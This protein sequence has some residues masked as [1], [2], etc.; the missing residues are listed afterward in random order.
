M[1]VHTFLFF[2]ISTLPVVRADGWD[3]FSNNLATDLAPFLSLFGEQV[4]KQFLSESISMLDYFIF[5]MAPMGILTAVVSVIRVCG[6][7]SLRAFIGRAQ[8]GAGDAE[9]ELCSSTSR[10]VCEL[11]NKGGIARVFGRPKILEIIHDPDH[12]F[13]DEK[14]GIYTFQEY[15]QRKG[16]NAWYRKKPNKGQKDAESAPKE[17]PPQTAAAPNLSLN[18]GIK[19]LSDTAFW[20]IALAGLVLQ[21]GVLVFAGVVTYYLK[22][23]KDGGRPES[24]ACPLVM[25]GT[26]LVCSGMFYCAFLIGQSTDEEVWERN[27]HDI[28]SMYWVQ[29]GGQIVGDQ[30]FDAFSYTDSEDPK[31][32][33]QQYTTSRKNVSVDSK[34]EVWIAVGITISGFVLQFIGLRGIHS[35]VSVAQLGVV[36]VMSMARAALRMRRVEPD[37]NS[38]AKFPDEVLGHE[39]DWLAL[40]IGQRD[41]R[42]AL[43]CPSRGSSP[44]SL[45]FSSSSTLS[46][47]D[48]PSDPRVRYFWRFCG[49]SDLTDRI[50]YK[51]SPSHESPNAAAKLLAYRTRLAELTSSSPALPTSGAMDFKTEMVEVRRESQKLADLIEATVNTIFSIAKVKNEWKEA[52]SMYWGIKCTLCSKSTDLF[53]QPKDAVVSRKQYTV[54]LELTRSKD[55]EDF[56]SVGNPWKL[57]DTGRLELEGLLGLWIWSLKSDPAIEA[58]DP[59]TG[60]TKSGAAGVDA[61]QIVST[62]Q[63]FTE[64]ALRIWLGG[65][66]NSFTKHKLYCTPTDHGDAS[67]IWNTDMEEIWKPL[68]ATRPGQQQIRF[69][70]WNAAQFS[71]IQTPEVFGLWSVPTKSSL[72]SSCTKEV[73]ASLTTCVLGAVDDIGSIDIQEADTFRLESSLVT[74]IV[75]LFTEMD[76]GSRQEALT[77]VV[78]LLISR[79]KISSAENVLAAARRNANKHRRGKRWEKAQAVLRWAWE[80]CTRFQPSHTYTVDGDDRH[81]LSPKDTLA[82]QAA[83]ALG[84]LYRWALVE[85][86]KKKFGNDGIQWLKEQKSNQLESTCE[87]IDRYAEIAN[88]IERDECGGAELSAAIETGSLTTTLISLTRPEFKMDSKQ[89]GN[90]LCLA[91][92]HGWVEVTLALLE[93]SAEPEFKDSTGRTPLSY[94]A[95]KGSLG[96][97]REL[98]DWGS[99]PNSEDSKHRT[100]L[101]Y[102][103]EVGASDVAE[104]LLRDLRVSPDPADSAGCTPLL[105]AAKNGHEI[106]V[107][108]LLKTGKVN[109][110]QKDSDKQTPI[111][112]AAKNGHGA[113][114]KQLL[115]MGQ[116]GLN[117]E[118]RDGFTLL[119]RAAK[120]G[121]TAVVKEL[122]A[123]K[124][125]NLD[126]KDRYEYT[127]LFWAANN[128]HTAVVKQLLE[129]GQVDPDV[130]D[131]HGYTPLLCAARNGHEPI[132]KQL[133]KTGKLDP[134]RKNASGETPLLLAARKGHQAVVNQLLQTGEVDPDAKSGYMQT[135]LW[136]AA[137][138]GHEAVVTQ[139][140]ATHQVDPDAKSD[141]GRTPLWWALK[142]KHEAIVTQLLA[143]R[144]VDPHPKDKHGNTPL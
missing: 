13:H 72:L 57:K 12:G 107:N 102:A 73:F 59:E 140:L 67:T 124:Q 143:T 89:K 65:D 117:Q 2:A 1:P 118:D 144:K 99:F 20:A 14:A 41:I 98:I 42:D 50:R 69:F 40:R 80:I 85:E 8:E 123:A 136:W 90:A 39:L 44:P 139:L 10:D 108:Q 111:W 48:S 94:A 56:N 142:N 60:F 70:G 88:G 25:I 78:P 125:V 4:T 33:L 47:S 26:L 91:A 7:A 68:S 93:L 96:V 43:E 130:K 109:L 49:A 92:K 137:R 29:P 53:D 86:D 45:S 30:T 32:R 103:S 83:I 55:S 51:Q 19:K 17:E 74:E 81:L 54:Y 119:G 135:P 16:K 76:L 115:T 28:S 34:L 87:V 18:I 116:V 133:L 5:A 38:F 64:S 61:R 100:P 95:E 11:Y 27:D 79:L 138:E 63:N 71:Q 24:Y 66:T 31:I 132:V 134:N 120:D 122:L 9:A 35:T 110:D 23:E 104:L 112:H 82:K 58:K 62:D 131:R 15:V 101:S 114:V 97:V 36:M 46:P 21:G 105:W 141:D 127:P 106:I 22:W 84:E 77:C 37:A 52:Q 121:H 126:P 128:G 113:V 75:K 129:T 6:S 3:D